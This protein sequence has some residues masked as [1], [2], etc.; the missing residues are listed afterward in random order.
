MIAELKLRHRVELCGSLSQVDVFS[1]LRSCDIF[2]LASVVDTAGAS[3]VFPTVIMEVMACAKPVVS[4]TLAGI[5]ESVVDGVTGAEKARVQLP[6]DYLSDGPL[7]PMLGVGYLDG[8]HPSL[9]AKMKN[10]V[11]NGAF[12]M[13]I[14]SWDY[15][16]AACYADVAEA[17]ATVPA[18]ERS[19]YRVF[20]YWL[21]G[22]DDP[23]SLFDPAFPPVP[24]GDGPRDF[25]ALG[26]DVVE[27][28][29]R[30]A[31]GPAR[32]PGFGHSPLSCN[33]LAREIRVNRYCLVDDREE[34]LRLVARFNREQPE[35]GT[36]FAVL[37][38]RERQGGASHA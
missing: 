6:T 20:A 3:D 14:V 5:P 38:A 29:I 27:I 23:A 36:Y 34:A 35:P 12:N 17:I 16:G 19:E 25:E 8:V 7:A 21:L 2:A 32:L 30:S 22:D 31:S 15:N 37:V 33:L 13:M 28:P 4:T 1:K 11:G 26:F 24:G 18:G 9:V 10:R